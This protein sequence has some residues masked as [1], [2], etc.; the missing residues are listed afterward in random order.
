MIPTGTPAK[1]RPRRH[2]Q[3]RAELERHA[4][5]TEPLQKLPMTTS[6][7][8]ALQIGLPVPESRPLALATSDHHIKD[9]ND[10]DAADSR[11]RPVDR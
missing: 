7:L 11:R 6:S 1:R 10:N 8:S 4:Q 9:V 5:P 2:P 3:R